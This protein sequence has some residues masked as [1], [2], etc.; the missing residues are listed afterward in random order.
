M[1][2]V[3]GPAA[4]V[5]FVTRT[6]T[7]RAHGKHSTTNHMGYMSSNGALKASPAS[8]RSSQHYTAGCYVWHCL[9]LLNIMLC[10]SMTACAKCTIQKHNYSMHTSLSMQNGYCAV[11]LFPNLLGVATYLD[12]PQDH[13]W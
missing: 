9:L 12:V 2:P 11:Y 6:A 4:R 3:L 7:A 13:C 8:M 1:H 10:P 5:P